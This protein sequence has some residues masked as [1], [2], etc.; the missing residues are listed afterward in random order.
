MS[1][2]RLT[3]GRDSF[4]KPIVL[5]DS[6]C[7]R[8]SDFGFHKTSLTLGAGR[9][10]GQAP[11]RPPSPVRRRRYPHRHSPGRPFDC[12]VSSF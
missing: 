3:L 12:L 6:N 7:T 4:F 8:D 1:R 11:N 10:F 5:P 2:S 9:C